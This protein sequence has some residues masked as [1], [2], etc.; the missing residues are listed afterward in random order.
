MEF[1]LT[2]NSIFGGFYSMVSKNTDINSFELLTRFD[3]SDKIVI[4][5]K[6]IY[7]LKKEN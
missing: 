5:P 3:Y 7:F 6:G 1:I 2:I 4:I